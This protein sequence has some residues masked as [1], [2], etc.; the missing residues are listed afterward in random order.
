MLLQVQ[1]VA[2]TEDHNKAP[3]SC[4][5]L[6]AL[7]LH[8]KEFS[9][10][11]VCVWLCFIWVFLKG[12]SVAVVLLTPWAWT[13][14]KPDP[15]WCFDW[16]SEVNSEQLHQ[17]GTE[18]LS[19]APRSAACLKHVTMASR[20]HKLVGLLYSGMSTLSIYIRIHKQQHSLNTHCAGTRHT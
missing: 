18:I 11:V 16:G 4:Y 5:Q 1:Q 3:K 8:G 14:A 13:M 17:P 20:V 19:A 12:G 7:C 2:E 15:E 9:R 10:H 6:R